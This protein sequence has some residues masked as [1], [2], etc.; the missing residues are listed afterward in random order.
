MFNKNEKVFSNLLPAVKFRK[1]AKSH[2]I[3]S[4]KKLLRK[5]LLGDATLSITIFRPDSSQEALEIFRHGNIIHAFELGP[6]IMDGRIAVAEHD[7][8]ALG[9][10]VH[11]IECNEPLF[12][13][14]VV[15]FEQIGLRIYFSKK[16][17]KNVRWDTV[18]VEAY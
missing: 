2:S 8:D 3:V 4:E 11:D 12:K 14:H 18:V 7:F 6:V 13:R 16:N 1:F 5:C 17:F 15:F 10:L 9:G